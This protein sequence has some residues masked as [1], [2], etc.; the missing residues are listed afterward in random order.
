M[1]CSVWKMF[2]VISSPVKYVK[3]TP[4]MKSRTGISIDTQKKIQYALIDWEGLGIP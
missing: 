3:S 2:S 4:T 1:T